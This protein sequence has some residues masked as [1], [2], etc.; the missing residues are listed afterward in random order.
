MPRRYLAWIG[1]AA[2]FLLVL[3]APPTAGGPHRGAALVAA[4]PSSSTFA[5]RRSEPAGPRRSGC[6]PRSRSSRRDGRARVPARRL[7]RH[8]ELPLQH[9]LQDR[10]TRPGSSSRSSRGVGVLWSARL[11][12]APAAVAWLV[13]LGVLVALG[14]RLSGRRLLLAHERLLARPDARR[15]GAGSDVGAR[16]RGR[17]RLAPPL[18][19][20]RADGRSR[21]WV[22]TSIPRAAAASRRSPA[23]P[24]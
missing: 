16:R 7:R 4:S 18:R 19:R 1:R 15:H 17:D 21:R 10:A 13:G 6:S 2:L 20:R 24:R 9:G 5:T 14:A 8:G 11:A 3:L 12:R 22:P 23:F